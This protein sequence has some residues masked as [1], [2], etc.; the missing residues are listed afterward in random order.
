MVGETVSEPTLFGTVLQITFNGVTEL[1]SDVYFVVHAPHAVCASLILVDESAAGGL[2]YDELIKRDKASLDRLLAQGR[3]PGGCGESP[4]PGCHRHGN[5][6]RP[7][8]RA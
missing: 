4:C 6:G 8:G 7:T 3:Q 2:T 1:G 5:N